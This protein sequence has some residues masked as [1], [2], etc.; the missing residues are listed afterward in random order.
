MGPR[1]PRTVSLSPRLSLSRTPLRTSVLGESFVVSP[2]K[3]PVDIIYSLVQDVASKTND[4]AGDGTT[5]ATVLA[6]AIYSEGV[7]NVAA[8]CNPMDLRRGA[9]KAVD[10]VL[11]VLAA[12]KKV[13]TTSEEIAQVCRDNYRGKRPG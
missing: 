1:S 7:K 3:L 5:T 11:E 12:N 6:R 10:K 13:I 2:P 8:G 9:Q 4:T